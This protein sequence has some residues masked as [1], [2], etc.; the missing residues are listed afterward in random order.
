MKTIE[1]AVKEAF[2]EIY[3]KNGNYLQKMHNNLIDQLKSYGTI[4]NK[5]N[6]DYILIDNIE[7]EI[8]DIPEAFTSDKWMSTFINGISKS[9]FFIS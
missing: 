3:F 1:T 6:K 7:H 2:I 8:P 9:Q 4:I 5:N